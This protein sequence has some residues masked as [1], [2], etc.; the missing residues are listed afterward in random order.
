MLP[1][2]ESLRPGREHTMS[3][4]GTERLYQAV[5]VNFSVA[6]PRPLPLTTTTSC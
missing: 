6:A 3:A 1:M 5:T 4:P 2:V